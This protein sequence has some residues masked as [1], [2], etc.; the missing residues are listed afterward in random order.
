MVRKIL[1]ISLCLLMIAPEFASRA[2]AQQSAAD[3]TAADKATDDAVQLLREDLRSQRKQLV[4]ANLPLTDVEATKFWP[5]FDRYTAELTK[6]GDNRYA[7]AKEYAQN[8]S[9]LTDA[10]ANTLIKNFLASDEALAQLR[11]KWLG[12]FQKVI[13]STKA[14]RF[15]QIDR[16]LSMLIDLQIASEVPLAK[17]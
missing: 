1:W 9:T 5:V 11:T 17:P 3:K 6:V 7:L 10:Q 14:A 4:A 12:E 8:Y 13:P 16:R 15:F 2:S